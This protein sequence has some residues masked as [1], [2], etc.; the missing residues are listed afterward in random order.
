MLDTVLD[1]ELFDV[2]RF[3]QQL[4]TTPQP[5]P[6]FRHALKSAQAVLQQRFL[7]GHSAVELVA[8]HARVIDI[9]LLYAWRQYLPATSQDIALVAVGGYGRGE[10]HPHSDV[11]ILILL[12]KEQRKLQEP[13]STFLTFLWDIG[14]AVGHSVR[15]LKECV[16]EAKNDIT[17]ATNL[18]EA[19][20]IVGQNTLLEE[21]RKL[22]GPKK[23]WPSDKFFAAKWQEQLTRHQKFND[24]AYNLEPNIK[25]G[26]GGLRDIQMIGWVAKRHFDANDLHDLVTH[27]FLNEHEYTT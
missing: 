25:E 19:R 15:T 13:I 14:L 6:L 21:Q 7:E 5:L 27:D 3:E 10:L 12:R 22:C 9:I 8:A 18:Q 17:V 20:L 4:T 26:P 1:P 11:D 2:S 23:L 24:T 16:R